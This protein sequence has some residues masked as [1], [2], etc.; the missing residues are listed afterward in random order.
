MGGLEE[1]SNVL[2]SVTSQ[3]DRVEAMLV[4]NVFAADKGDTWVDDDV[5]GVL[6]VLTDKVRRR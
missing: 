5:L 2:G 1:A 6:G 4:A 3:E